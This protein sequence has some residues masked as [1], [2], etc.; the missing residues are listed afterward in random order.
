MSVYT[1]LSLTDIQQ[2]AN[3]YNLEIVS[4]QPIQSGIENSNYFVQN[5]DGREFVLTLFEELNAEE[6]AFLAPLLQHLQQAAYPLPRHST[7]IM[8][9]AC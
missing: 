6:A 8:A 5:N 9:K 1:Q 3:Q 4:C 7:Q 2:F